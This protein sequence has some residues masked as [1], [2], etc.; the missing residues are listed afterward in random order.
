MLVWGQKIIQ[1]KKELFKFYNQEKKNYISKHKKNIRF[2]SYVYSLEIIMWDWKTKNTDCNVLQILI[3]V[4]DKIL[5]NKNFI[6]NL[7]IN[8]IYGE[9]K[10]PIKA[11]LVTWFLKDI[12]TSK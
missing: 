6:K 4:F 12:Y 5:K 3:E 10:G 1:K 8:Y 7:F 2:S 9:I 11:L